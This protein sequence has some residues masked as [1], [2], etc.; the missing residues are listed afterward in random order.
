VTKFCYADDKRMSHRCAYQALAGSVT[1]DI[2]KYL[3]RVE[4]VSRVSTLLG[5]MVV[6]VVATLTYLRRGGLKSEP[7]TLDFF[8]RHGWLGRMPGPAA[9]L[10]ATV[11]AICAHP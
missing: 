4:C 1:I 2:I 3:I 5:A 6:T 8:S 7:F 11:K 9:R 10:S